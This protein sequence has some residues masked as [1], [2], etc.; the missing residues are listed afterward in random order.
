MHAKGPVRRKLPKSAASGDIFLLLEEQKALAKELML[1]VRELF[2]YAS[3]MQET[4]LSAQSLGD[5][6]SLPQWNHERPQSV[7][8]PSKLSTDLNKRSTSSRSSNPRR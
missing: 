6:R 3:E 2:C 4:V 8:T 5:I 7:Q 1:L